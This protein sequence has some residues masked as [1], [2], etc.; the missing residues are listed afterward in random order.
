MAL[1][2]RRSRPEGETI[3]EFWQWWAAT[4]GDVA[5]AISAGTVQRF[6]EEI[7]RQVHA[8]HADLQ[9]ELAPGTSSTHTLVVTSAGQ[10]ATRA[11]A[12]RWLAAAPPADGTWSYRCLRAA[13]PSAFESRIELD[14]HTL[15]LAH[16]RYG[17]AVDKQRRQIDVVC[18]HPGFAGLPDNVQAQITFL[19]LDW[20]LG[21]QN[22][23]VWLGEITWSAV[24]PPN[25]G[26]PADLRH[27]VDALTGDEDSWVL[28]QGQRRD[29][30]PLLATAASPL[31][32]ARWPRFDLHMPIRLPYQRF[33]EG[34]LPVEESLAALRRFED[35]LSAAIATNGT[36][37]AHE[38][39]GRERTLHFYVDSQT[40]ARAELESH[41]PHWRE[42]RASVKPQLDPAF[43]G[44]RHLM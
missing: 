37:V 18:H 20:A 16:I 6:A 15:E 1:F 2:R 12:A 3:A 30:T 35:D 44:V 29:G 21:E 38:T 33:N 25:L 41:L 5:A 19:T 43:E 14:G 22:V 36:L 40:N 11:V 9:W 32:S 4:R 8:I 39:G 13:D 24:V 17:I 31:R 23:E 10:A 26:T 7:G 27:A 42:G 34:L 28:M